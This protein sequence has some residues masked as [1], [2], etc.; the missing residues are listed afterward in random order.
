VSNH[1]ASDTA[2]VSWSSLESFARDQVQRFIQRILE[3]EI[4]EHLGRARSARRAPIDA[5]AGYR[6]G[7][8]K[9]RRLA[10][11]SGT[12]TLRRPRVSDTDEPFRSKILPLF[13]RRT[14]EI[15]ALLPDLYLHGLSLGDFELALRGLLGEG[16]PLSPS[17]IARLKAPWQLEYEEWGQR[18][19][20]DRELVYAWAD[21]V[22]VKAGLE[23][24]KSCLLVIV[25]AMR[26][27]RKEL[28]ALKSGHRESK[29]SWSALL[30][31]L[32]ERGLAVPPKLLVGDGALG[33]WAAAAEVWPQTRAGRCWNHKTINVL[34]T[35]PKRLQPGAT[36]L[37]REMAA[38]P[39]RAEAER[40]REA[41]ARRCS[42]F[43]DAAACLARDWEAL[44]AFYDFPA[45]HWKHLRTS[46]VV[47]SP[48]ASL[49]LRT[50][51]AKRFK[52]VAN[53][54]MLI[55]KVLRVAESR[56]R[57]L[58]APDLLKDVYEGRE[59][60]NGMPVTRSIGRKAA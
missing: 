55:W 50:D 4:S 37:L 29:E 35:L 20:S 22:Y 33:L 12:I 6:N 3:E 24:D 21:G 59:F 23:K 38:A 46:N 13:A 34:D 10:M 48:F 5:P 44:T 58:D 41:F 57:T 27:G 19:L 53:A 16:A 2:G 47:E 56:W 28:L 11:A 7:H 26:D 17:S 49:R 45:E 54:T 51:A 8:G 32:R 30:R 25:G 36:I 60:A 39:T 15:G 42:E 43:P 18:D 14:K 40:L 31:D 9:E 52:V 1:S